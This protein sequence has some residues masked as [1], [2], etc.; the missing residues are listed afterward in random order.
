VED[1]QSFPSVSHIVNESKHKTGI[2]VLPEHQDD[3]DQEWRR[4]MQ[5]VFD[6]HPT[7]SSELNDYLSTG[8]S[9]GRKLK[10]QIMFLPPGMHFKIHAHPNIEFIVTLR[11]CLL[12]FRWS[13]CVPS[14]ELTGETPTGPEIAANSVFEHRSLE[15][16]QCMLNEVGSVHQSFTGK[17]PCAILV[18]WSGCHANTEPSK[19]HNSDERLKPHAGWD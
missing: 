8:F 18:L 15:T 4:A 14:H 17:E 12:E 5:Q 1:P 2:Q 9:N 11:G 16:G 10:L 13:F 3:F 7:A 6:Q 19:C